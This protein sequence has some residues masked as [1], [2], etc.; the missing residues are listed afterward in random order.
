MDVIIDFNIRTYPIYFPILSYKSISF[1]LLPSRLY[2]RLW[3][4]TTSACARG[5]SPPVGN[6]TLPRR[7]IL[8]KNQDHTKY[9]HFVYLLALC[10]L[11]L[12]HPSTAYSSLPSTK[13]NEMT[14]TKQ[15][16]N[17]VHLSKL[18]MLKVDI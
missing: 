8:Y 5:L 17:C 2:C 12:L 3:N 7:L 15:K 9:R 1:R 6:Y 13:T 11:A 4:C 14:L 10:S 18:S 16:I